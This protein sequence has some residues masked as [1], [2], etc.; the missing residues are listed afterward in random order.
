MSTDAKIHP[1]S[2]ISPGATLGRSVTVGPYSLINANVSVGDG[3][4]V[5]SHSILGAPTAGYYHGPESHEPA[6]CSIG[7][8]SV[9]RSHAVVYEGVTIGD[10]FEC[11]HHVTIRERT[12][13][14][15]GVR[16]GTLCDLQPEV[17]IG[18]HVRL[19][20]NVF[21]ARGSTVEDLVWL[22]PYALLLD[23]P[24]P[25]SDACTQGPT[26]RKFAVVGARATIL[27]AVE[28][29][30]G[31]VVGGASLV[32]HNVPADTVVVGV[33]ARVVG[34]TSDVVC[35]HGNIERVYP[36]WHHFRRGYPEGVLPDLDNEAEI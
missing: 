1:T 6:P 34:P 25:P 20:S 17:A 30:E 22:F 28:V 21:V 16:V 8:N 31:A 23:D 2:I 27:S 10:D 5:D 4:F 29:G 7:S 32:R 33:P 14:G 24:H 13:I 12:R 35:R 18:N 26:I 19:H 15:V 11:G 36:W 3:T 9:I